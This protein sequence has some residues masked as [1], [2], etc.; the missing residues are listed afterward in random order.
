MGPKTAFHSGI[1]V[2]VGLSH[3]IACA[4]RKP[5]NL[6][7]SVVAS[8]CA[9]SSPA[10]A[11][12]KLISVDWSHPDIQK[13]VAEEAANPPRMLAAAE[14]GQLAKLKL[15]VVGFDEVPGL[16][17]SVPSV[18]PQA[19]PEPT[20]VMDEDNPVWYEIIHDYGDMTVSVSADLRVQHTADANFK[21]YDEGPAGAA[22]ETGGLT[23]SVFDEDNQEA[24][25]GFKAEYTVHKYGDIPY[26]VVIEC[27]EELK[28]SCRDR[29]AIA[30]DSAALRIISAS[31]PQQ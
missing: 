24:I 14:Q 22:P 25:E 5:R 2:F 19:K 12:E 27:S 29:A 4:V 18:G 23:V 9:I 13:F 11:D 26:R 3:Q 1:S 6:A 8:I 10:M 15:P 17:A 30:R 21:V 7:I 31:P 28:D 20:V 16:F